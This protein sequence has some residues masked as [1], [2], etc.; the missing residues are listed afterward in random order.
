MYDAKSSRKSPKKGIF[1]E[2]GRNRIRTIFEE[3]LADV[4]L[5]LDKEVTNGLTFVKIH[6]PKP[7]LKKYCEI[8]K[9]KMPLKEVR[10]VYFEH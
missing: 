6:V 2:D 7:V 10:E 3:N 1:D 4:G 5:E 8:M 9:F